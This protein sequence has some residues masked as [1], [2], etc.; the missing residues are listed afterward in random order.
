MLSRQPE[1][2]ESIAK[3]ERKAIH[4]S[5]LNSYNSDELI[6]GACNLTP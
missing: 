2:R 3:G 5:H 4:S 6:S 1:E